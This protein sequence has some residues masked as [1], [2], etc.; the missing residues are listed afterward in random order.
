[1]A[2]VNQHNA[3]VLAGKI[4]HEERVQNPAPVPHA[5]QC[6]RPEALAWCHEGEA[7]GAGLLHCRFTLYR[8]KFLDVDAKYASV[9]DLL[10]CLTIIRIIRGD[11]EGQ[12]S[13]EVNQV[14]A[15]FEETE[16]EVFCPT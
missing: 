2:Q 13:L 16:I 14:K 11:K 10:D 1:M 7:Q 4:K 8:K 3:R 12:I 6:E 9:K 15:K 5:K